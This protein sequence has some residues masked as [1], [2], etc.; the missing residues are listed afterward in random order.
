MKEII[1]Y[2]SSPSEQ[3]QLFLDDEVI[4]GVT[5][6]R[7]TLNQP[8]RCG[9]LLRP[10]GE[11]FAL[12]TWDPPFWNQDK[13]LWEWWYLGHHTASPHGKHQATAK[14]MVHYARSADGVHWE[15]PNLNL[16]SYR[17]SAENNIIVDPQLDPLRLYHMVHD[18]AESDSERRYKALFGPSGRKPAASPDGKTWTFLDVPPIP[19]SDTSYL[20]YDT[21]TGQFLATVKMETQW[22]RSVALSVSR[23]FEHWDQPELI[24]HT[25]PEDSENG[26][27][28]IREVIESENYLSPPL[29]DD[30]D[31]QAE[32]YQMAVLPYQGIYVGFPVLFNPAGTIPPPHNNF[33]ALNQVELTVSRDLYNWTRVADRELFMEVVPWDG[34]AYDTA[35]VYPCGSP[36]VR[37]DEIWIYYSANRF[38][39]SNIEL[40][41]DKYRPYFKDKSALN[42]AKLRLD[43][44]VSLD[45]DHRGGSVVTRPF[46][47]S[48]G[49]LT[50]NVDASSEGAE[51]RAEILDAVT[52]RVLQTY[53]AEECV[54]VRGDHLR[55]GL[56]WTGGRQK[57]LPRTLRLRFILSG[58]ISFYSFWISR[59][60]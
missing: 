18:P 38:R 28:R 33:T 6:L 10:P 32:I 46:Q 29:V 59:E 9:P 45:S 5:N 14:A 51:L 60:N 58:P 39:A 41:G 57:H 20:T 36:V 21:Q 19:S 56:E 40:Y 30:G 1:D 53:S 31:Y 4:E 42:L 12:E 3:R 27:R 15:T 13:G 37:D 24:L 26:E 25:D 52:L 23:D 11:P 2:A 44:F 54:P 8:T 47:Y 55:A 48:G 17:G 50:V 43:G 7:R 34:I 22:G 49:D 16:Y 35:G